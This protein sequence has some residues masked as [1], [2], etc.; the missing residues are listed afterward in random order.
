MRTKSNCRKLKRFE[1]AETASKVLRVGLVVKKCRTCGGFHLKRAGPIM[2]G[3]K[4][5]ESNQ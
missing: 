2:P 1:T 4:D 5:A 3:E